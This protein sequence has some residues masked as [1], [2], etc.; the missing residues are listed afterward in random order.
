MGFTGFPSLDVMVAVVAG[1]FATVG[2]IVALTLVAGVVQGGLA[3]AGRLAGSRRG[4][5]EIASRAERAAR[6]PA[7]GG[8]SQGPDHA[9][10]ARQ[11]SRLPC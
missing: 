11:A 1:L 2:A 5:A 3:M 7:D 9:P 10:S 6:P 8:G 4:D